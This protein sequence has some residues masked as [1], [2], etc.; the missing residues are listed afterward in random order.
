MPLSSRP[1]KRVRSGTHEATTIHHYDRGVSG[2]LAARSTRTAARDRDAGGL[3]AALFLSGRAVRPGANITGVA[4]LTIELDPKRLEL[5][6][7]LTLSGGPLAVLLNPS[8]P[9]TQIQVEGIKTAARSVGRELVLAYASTVQQI[10]AA[11]ATFA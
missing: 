3:F 9:D 5:L 2:N 7:E 10:D 1:F 4:A 11:F 8:R 6:H